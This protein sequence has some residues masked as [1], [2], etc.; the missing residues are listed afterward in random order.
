MGKSQVTAEELYNRIV[1]EIGN[2]GGLTILVLR[3]DGGGWLAKVYDGHTPLS[4]SGFQV[5]L[6]D[7]VARLRLQYDLYLYGTLRPMEGG[8]GSDRGWQLRALPAT[9]FRQ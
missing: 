5:A 1:G 9:S 7:I 6:D 2:P 4:K 8:L 3:S